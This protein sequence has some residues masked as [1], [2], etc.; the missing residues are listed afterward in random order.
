M[1]WFIARNVLNRYHMNLFDFQ[2][3]RKARSISSLYIVLTFFLFLYYFNKMRS[4][5]DELE[6]EY[7][8]TKIYI[9]HDHVIYEFCSIVF[10]IL[11]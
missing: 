9:T 3:F 1:L 7:I 5:S 6:F 8:Y 2:L 11:T 10:Y 4:S